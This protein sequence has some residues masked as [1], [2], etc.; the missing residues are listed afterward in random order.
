MKAK[1]TFFIAAAVGL[2][3]GATH[4][5]GGEVSVP[6]TNWKSIRMQEPRDA[7]D[8]TWKSSGGSLPAIF[9]LTD[10]GANDDEKLSQLLTTA[11]I[12]G[13]LYVDKYDKAVG[14]AEDG[15]DLA[16]V[17]EA[18]RQ[19]RSGKLGADA[20]RA[21]ASGEAVM[22]WASMLDDLVLASKSSAKAGTVPVATTTFLD[23]YVSL[24]DKGGDAD[25]YQKALNMVAVGQPQ[26]F[27]K[28]LSGKDAAEASRI[29]QLA[30]IEATAG[31]AG[32]AKP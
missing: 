22:L 7:M 6:V 20:G 16:K 14:G 15:A 5:F 10:G 4:V 2:A 9:L 13:H 27:D 31:S 24:S 25:I 1:H 23:A 32:D 30:G 29:R 19:A 18:V 21:V 12:I 17:E 3:A 8:V 26:L 28:Y 11:R